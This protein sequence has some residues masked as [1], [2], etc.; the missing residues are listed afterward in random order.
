MGLLII[1]APGDAGAV[2]LRV[3]GASVI[4]LLASELASGVKL[5][6]EVVDE[7][8]ASLGRVSVKLEALD[9]AGRPIRMDPPGPCA[10]SDPI[11]R[12]KQDGGAY[13]VTTDERGAF[14]VVAPGSFAGHTF[15][16]TFAGNKH[17]DP[18]DVTVSPVPESEQRAQVTVRFESPPSTLDLDKDSHFVTVSVRI[19]RADAQRLFIDASKKQGLELVLEDEAGKAIARAQTGGDGRVRFEVKTTDLGAPGDGE[20]KA[21]FAGDKQLMPAKASLQITRVATA[22]LAAPERVSGDPDGGLAFDVDVRTRHGAVEGGI[23]E[24]LL[25]K[26]P[27]GTGQVTGGKARV[28]VTFAGGAEA[29]VPLT[30]RYVASSPF[31]RAGP[32]SSITVHVKGPSPVRQLVLAAVGLALAGW[33]V[34]KWRRAPKRETSDSIL[35]P[36]PSGRPE[37][38]VLERPSGLKGWRGVV[39]DAH[40]GHPIA[41][42]ELRILVPA[43][44][45]RG[46]VARAT[47]DSDGTFS[48]DLPDAPKDARLVVEGDLHATF[49][50]PLPAPS[51][52]RVALVTRRRALLDRLVRWARTRGTPFDS[53]KEPTP[54]HVRRVA[55]RTGA[56]SV[57]TWASRVEEA[58]FGAEAV[59]RDVERTVVASE[60]STR[61]VEPHPLE[62]RP[63]QPE[64]GGA[65]PDG[66]QP[67]DP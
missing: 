64:A 9:R 22:E 3:R 53:S 34:A 6:G 48:L 26:D 56:G 29:E 57:E 52:L 65:P 1:L 66:P 46:E 37:I 31:F 16:A 36:P 8:G 14:C 42:V 23:V 27:V 7:M 50:Q 55:S 40:D 45:G 21:L 39:N 18:A 15:R 33:I 63:L 41:G 10:G 20:L 58:A 61:A 12:V 54:G 49:E 4:D 11:G 43:F 67:A 25:G 44:D 24:A 17:I 62:P 51:V 28:T 60:P 59:T 32:T 30:L 2:P 13:L 35:P 38:L 19:A 47:T 5:R